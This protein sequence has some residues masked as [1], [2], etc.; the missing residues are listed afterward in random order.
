MEFLEF[1]SF[2]KQLGLALAGAAAFWG[3]VL[4]IKS[5][6]PAKGPECIIFDWLAT[7]LFFLLLAGFG[8]ALCAWILFLFLMPVYAHEGIILVPSQQEVIR[9]L[10]ITSPVFAVW[11]VFVLISLWLN[12]FK[13]VLFGEWLSGIYV[14][15]FIFLLFLISLPAWSGNLNAHQWFYIG[16]SVHSIFTFGSVIVLD[17]LVLISMAVRSPAIKEHLYPMFPLI[18]KFIWVGLGID[19]LSVALVFDDAIQMTP[20]FFFMQT[21]VGILIINGTILSGPITRKMIQAV[22]N[23]G[24]EMSK[25]WMRAADLCGVISVSSWFTITFTDFFHHLTF[26]YWQFLLAYVS[27]IATLYAGHKIMQLFPI[28]LIGR[29]AE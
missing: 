17:F 26:Q 24:S 18:S 27:L 3:L 5:H 8:I 10:E 16:H 12:R 2:A 4:S 20:K 23:K 25:N 6:H 11:A 13:P 29:H 1:V 19:F 28:A 7:R 9:A 22:R 21:V 15:H 14:A